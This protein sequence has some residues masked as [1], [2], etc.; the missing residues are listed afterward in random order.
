MEPPVI[1]V[2]DDCADIDARDKSISFCSNLPQTKYS[3]ESSHLEAH[4]TKIFLCDSS[5]YCFL[6]L[7]TFCLKI[8]PVF[9]CIRK[10]AVVAQTNAATKNI[11]DALL[12]AE[13][14]SFRIV[15]SDNYYVQVSINM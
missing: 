4:K 2:T 15:V 12:K 1:C 14:K 3:H 11:A 9:A 13:F 8:V 6:P 5:L 7:N 10:F